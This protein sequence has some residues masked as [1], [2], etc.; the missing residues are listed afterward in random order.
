MAKKITSTKVEESITKKDLEEV[1][2]EIITNIETQYQHHQTMT[3][4]SQVGLELLP[5]VLDAI[6]KKI[7]DDK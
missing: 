7:N 6:T 4:K 2:K 3:I 5:Q 1:V